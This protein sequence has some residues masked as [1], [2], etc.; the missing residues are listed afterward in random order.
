[1]K[2]IF[3]TAVLSAVLTVAAQAQS[4][5]LDNFNSGTVT[6]SLDAGAIS[7]VGQVTQNASNLTV[8][9]T[10]KDESSWSHTFGSLQD[11]SAF[12]YLSITAQRDA[13]NVAANLSLTLAD[14]NG[15]DFTTITISTSS[16]NLGSM[17]TVIVPFTW[18]GAGM[19]IASWNL[20]GGQ[21]APGTSAFRMTF[22]NMQL[23]TTA[24]P[25][26]STYALIAGLGG[27]GLAFWRRRQATRA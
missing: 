26:P 23:Q 7:W 6:G 5:V 19:Q 14:D 15:S 3:K 24:V 22:D 4:I 25:E 9:G 21:A 11:L 17:T 20:G 2:N 18:T 13:G 12:T 8:G 1:M 10:A 16:F 27:L